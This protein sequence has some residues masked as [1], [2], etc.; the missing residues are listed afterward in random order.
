[1]S[2]IAAWTLCGLATAQTFTDRFDYPPGTM[3][4]G[5]TEQVGNWSATGGTVR[6]Q[7]LPGHQHLTRNG[8]L[9]R[10]ACVEVTAHYDVFQAQTSYLGPLVGHRNMGIASIYLML[11][12]EDAGQPSGGWDT[13]G[14]YTYV[15]SLVTSLNLGGTISPP[16]RAARARLQ[17]TDDPTGTRRVQLFLDTDLDGRWNVTR[18][19]TPVLLPA[20]A[21]GF[22]IAGF[23][24]AIADDLKYFD[25]TLYLNDPPRVGNPVR[26]FGRSLPSRNWQGACSLGHSGI[27]IGG[28]RAI[29]LDADALLALSLSFPGFAGV[30][31][32]SG[33]FTMT[34]SIPPAP[35]LAGLTVW[36]SAVTWSAGIDEIAP[37]VEVRI[38]P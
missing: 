17:V 3:I 36:C 23:G 9:D 22:G 8:I 26:L 12:L 34:L 31:D 4:P 10:D 15:D 29:P 32:A 13:Y 5:W 6:T 24:P 30:T 25:A 20:Q 1:M 38:A 11:R 37:D 27:P 33:G 7:T 2:L 21:A 14:V 35:V 19:G 28:G 18:D 16:T